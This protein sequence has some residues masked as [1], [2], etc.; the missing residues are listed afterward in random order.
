M[1][2]QLRACLLANS[3]LQSNSC[4]FGTTRPHPARSAASYF[5]SRLAANDRA[6][7]YICTF[8]LPC[9]ALGLSL[10][11]CSLGGQHRVLRARKISVFSIRE[12]ERVVSGRE[13]K[14]MRLSLQSPR[15][16]SAIYMRRQKLAFEASPVPASLPRPLQSLSTSLGVSLRSFS[17]SFCA[18]SA[19][20]CGKYTSERDAGKSWL[21]GTP[22]RARAHRTLH[23]T[24]AKILCKASVHAQARSRTRSALRVHQRVHTHAHPHAHTYT[25]APTRGRDSAYTSIACT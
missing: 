11:C 16:R 22:S 20:L 25:Q 15:L 18:R 3:Q 5:N 4:S 12:R 14:N 10:S 19:E 6:M 13:Y 21:S 1:L 23:F 2:Q 9:I 17:R 7:A 8:Y 24:I